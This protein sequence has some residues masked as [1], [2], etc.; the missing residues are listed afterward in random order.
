MRFKDNM[1]LV[2]NL[3]SE[4]LAQLRLSRVIETIVDSNFLF[5]SCV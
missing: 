5:L 2:E 3:C 4:K 1:L